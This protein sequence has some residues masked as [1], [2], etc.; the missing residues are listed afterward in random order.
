MDILGK[1]FV[2]QA[3][4]D[5][6]F[7]IAAKGGTNIALQHVSATVDDHRMKMIGSDG[8]L[9]II[10]S[11]DQL[12]IN[13]PGDV[14]FSSSIHDIIKLCADTDIHIYT[15][16]TSIFVECAEAFFEIRKEYLEYPY[17][18]DA[19]EN[20]IEVPKEALQNAI[21]KCR[22]AITSDSIRQS[23]TFIQVKDSKMRATDGS[24][25]H[26]V[27]FPYPV[28]ALI[29]QRAIADILRRIRTMAM[30]N[31]S[32]GNTDHSETF[33]FDNDLL[34]ITK[35]TVDYPDVDSHIIEP[36]SKNNLK[37]SVERKRLI[38]AVKRISQT[39][40]EE[41]HYL[42][43]ELEPSRLVLS[44][45]DKYGSNS[46]ETLDV[47]W[48]EGSRKIGVNHLYL[49]DV[50]S[51]ID[52]PDVDITLGEDEPMKLSSLCFRQESFIGVLMQLRPDLGQALQ[53]SDKVRPAQQA[54]VGWGDSGL[55][56]GDSTQGG[57]R[58]RA[59]LSESDRIEA[60]DLESVLETDDD[61]EDS[62][63][64]PGARAMDDMD[65]F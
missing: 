7:G 44:S 23:F 48:D 12:D 46:K 39:A 33:K 65:G 29:P 47:S 30:E 50:L 11:C 55:T 41:T 61:D 15:N 43:L 2:M 38:E 3:A 13:E 5:K 54:P 19:H 24:K 57:R 10:V 59:R 27:S 14:L 16:E 28:E 37:L 45:M 40:D 21:Q 22:P 25:C 35:H 8:E 64:S 9:S 36:A 4:F 31:V 63:G 51:V 53:G 26:Q 56:A 18:D 42:T 60:E 32:I 1:K 62:Y 58:T 17:I 34:I 52:T 49:R 20:T 6:A